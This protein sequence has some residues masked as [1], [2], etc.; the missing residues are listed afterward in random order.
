MMGCVRGGE[1]WISGSDCAL[2]TDPALLPRRLA[3]EL[4]TAHADVASSSGMYN[5]APGRLFTVYAEL[6]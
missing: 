1:N 4:R 3:H 5:S 6:T 2:R